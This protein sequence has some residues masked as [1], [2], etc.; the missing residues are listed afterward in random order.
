MIDNQLHVAE[1]IK[2]LENA[3]VKLRERLDE[4]TADLGLTPSNT[5]LVIERVNVMKRIVQAQTEIDRLRSDAAKL[6]E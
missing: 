1:R 6:S 2:A 3:L 4:V 5:R